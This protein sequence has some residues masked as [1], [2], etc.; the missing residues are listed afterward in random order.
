MMRARRAYPSANRISFFYRNVALGVFSFGLFF[1]PRIIYSLEN[2]DS[3]TLTVIP[4]EQR[5]F[6]WRHKP[7]KGSSYDI[8]AW[9]RTPHAGIRTTATVISKH[10]ILIVVQSDGDI[11]IGLPVAFIHIRLIPFYLLAVGSRDIYAVTPNHECF[12]GQPYDSFNKIF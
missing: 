1:R 8:A 2:D 12:A 5:Q 9:Y 3:F 11:V 6:F 7:E 4:G 10:V